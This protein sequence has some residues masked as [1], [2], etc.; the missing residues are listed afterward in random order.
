MIKI[1]K[2]RI[3]LSMVLLSPLILA[4]CG[5]EEGS[6]V[7]NN[8]YDEVYN[9]QPNMTTLNVT[10]PTN[11]TGVEINPVTVS[12]TGT[13][14]DGTVIGY[15]YR[16]SDDPCN[17]V[18]ENCPW[19]TDTFVVFTSLATGYYTFEVASKD[20]K[21]AVD[22]IDYED[23]I[24]V[25]SQTISFYVDSTPPAV[26]FTTPRRGAGDVPLNRD[27]TATFNEPVN[28]ASIS[29]TLSDG[30]GTVSG[31]VTYAFST[32]SFNPDALVLDTVY[33][34]TIQGSLTDEAGNPMG[35]DY[36]WSFRTSA[37][38]AT[39]TTSPV[40]TFSTPV[41][42]A[43]QVPVDSFVSLTFN[44]PVDP[45]T[46]DD[47]SFTLNNGVL[48]D[49]FLSGMTAIFK[50]YTLLAY[51]RTYTSTVT[52]AVTDLADNNL[53]SPYVWSFKTLSSIPS[54]T[55]VD[56]SNSGP[57]NSP[58][59]VTSTSPREGESNVAPNIALAATFSEPV[60]VSTVTIDTFSL[61]YS[62]GTPI[63]GALYVSGATALF[64]PYTTLPYSTGYSGTIKAGITGLTGDP[65]LNDYSWNFT[66]G[67]APDVIPPSV[68]QVTPMS[69]A[70]GVAASSSI[71]AL[72][73]EPLDHQT[74]SPATFIV[75]DE[76]SGSGVSGSVN[77]YGSTATFTPHTSLSY[78]SLF[79]VT[80][81]KE[82]I[83]LAGNYLSTDY[84]W[85]FT[86]GS[87]PDLTPPNVMWTTPTDGDVNIDIGTSITA[88]FSEPVNVQTVSTATFTLRDGSGSSVEG[89]VSSNG[90]TTTFTPLGVLTEGTTYDATLSTAIRDSAGNHFEEAISWVFTT[91]YL[92]D[93]TEPEVVWYSPSSGADPVSY[94]SPVIVE[95]SEPVDPSTLNS[96]TFTLDISGTPVP[97]SVYYDGDLTAIFQ[98]LTT[99]A[100]STIHTA[101]IISGP[102][103]V[104]D[105]AGN[106]LFSGKIWDFTTGTE[107]DIV[108]PAIAFTN[109]TSG[110]TE[111]S[112]WD[113][114]IFITFDE[115]VDASTVTSSTILL[116]DILY[117]PVPGNVY[118]DG[119]LT[120]LFKPQ[121]DLAYNMQYLATVKTGAAGVKDLAG[122]F[123]LYSSGYEWS[124]STGDIPISLAHSI[125]GGR[126]HSIAIKNDL[127]AWAWGYNSEGQLGDGTTVTSP[128]PVPIVGILDIVALSASEYHNLAVNLDGG[129]WSWGA[130]EKGQLGIGT[131]VES[132][133]PIEIS[134]FTN[135]RA[136]DAGYFFSMALKNDGTVWTWGYNEDGQLG[137]GNSGYGVMS[138]TPTQVSDL[139]GK[140]VVA[141]AAGDSHALA[142]TSTGDVYAWGANGLGQLG[143]GSDIPASLP[144][145]VS[146]LS[147]IVAIGAGEY[148][149]MAL[150]SDGRVYTWGSNWYGQLGLGTDDT[151]L[152]STPAQVPGLTGII[153]VDGGYWHTIALQNDGDVFT[154]GLN[155]DGQLGNG[156][157]NVDPLNTDII[158]STP[159]QVFGIGGS[160][161]LSSI[162]AVAAGAYHSVALRNSGVTV[163]WGYND[164]G[165]L[166]NCSYDLS[167]TPVTV[168]W[169]GCP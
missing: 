8:P 10:S 141:I 167:P 77:Y 110:E 112:V 85:H 35:L 117:G 40:V 87:E 116:E 120:A 88:T 165:T 5:G 96:L 145:K 41:R 62:G 74:V 114:R 137:D 140:Q 136:V 155:D 25:A 26:S 3:V 130:N 146:S 154:W 69:G 20:S 142:L 109:P 19:T 4:S 99:L 59:T 52:T 36:S 22:I 61:T 111:I 144:M 38:G 27:L 75:Y 82:M 2:N 139:L 1:V 71:S 34:A 168:V 18:A 86:T 46:V 89:N 113:P 83:D 123:M 132:I 58:P 107:P 67:S 90:T 95:F 17:L 100:W 131:Y 118:Y 80:L 70:K 64:I 152:H 72:F 151:E 127:T 37:S 21:G 91:G 138:P 93:E 94:D 105:L 103:G 54:S 133:I 14:P 33:T 125:A 24:D 60:D 106:T 98:P 163:T 119:V 124:F 43:G 42:N 161:Y 15:Y 153:Q 162:D 29:I 102:T 143:D 73:S 53:A 169:T 49:V 159:V 92:P 16:F 156:I 9:R 44:E 101:T 45:A 121:T 76:G 55:P 66:T 104:K 65:L 56:P 13:D 32:A 63:E 115:P 7:F 166:G 134:G 122:N 160:G 135:V 47:I 126:Y 30:A 148:H 6:Y 81:K 48:G 39:D 79:T 147:G 84:S 51:N 150:T 108:N 11:K 128:E 149:S 129:I 12:F 78:D 158:S 68:S 50:P 23:S 164:V 57:D 28:P 31:A 157:Y 97:G